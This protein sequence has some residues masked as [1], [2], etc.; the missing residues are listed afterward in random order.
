MRTAY[1]RHQESVTAARARHESNCCWHLENTQ[2]SWLFLLLRRGDASCLDTEGCC[3]RQFDSDTV[4]TMKNRNPWEELC[5]DTGRGTRSA[6]VY[7][8]EDEPLGWSADLWP[9]TGQLHRDSPNL[10]KEVFISLSIPGFRC[11]LNPQHV[12]MC[13]TPFLMFKLIRK[14]NRKLL[15]G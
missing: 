12:L 3:L 11:N 15:H 2:W 7:S 6:G 5:P 8:S 1:Y 14:N 10:L 4:F 13:L 9:R